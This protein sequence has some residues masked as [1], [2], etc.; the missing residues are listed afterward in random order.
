MTVYTFVEKPLLTQLKSMGWEVREQ[1]AG[2]TNPIWSMRNSFN[3]V[4]IEDEFVKALNQLNQYNG[5]PWLT[6]EQLYRL[7]GQFSVF[8]EPSLLACNHAFI[9][10]LYHCQVEKNWLSGEPFPLVRV[11]DFENWQANRFLAIN[12]YRVDSGSGSSQQTTIP[13]IVLFVNG[14]PLVVISCSDFSQTILDPMGAATHYLERILDNRLS[15][16]T[17]RTNSSL[18]QLFYTNQFLVASHG[19]AC[20]Y[21]AL[22]S[23]KPFYAK[24]QTIYPEEVEYT[25]AD[26]TGVIGKHRQQEQLVQGLLAPATLLNI[27]RCFT[28]FYKK[29]GQ[30]EKMVCRYQHYRAVHKALERLKKEQ[31]KARSGI[32]EHPQGSGKT[33]MM[34]F[35]INNIRAD[36]QLRD[37]KILVVGNHEM[38]MFI[39]ELLDETAYRL[40]TYADL[41]N[42][43]S[44]DASTLNLMSVSKLQAAAKSSENAFGLL[45][46]SDK[47]L[48]LSSDLNSTQYFN[49]T[50]AKAFDYFASALPGAVHLSFTSAGK[51]AEEVHQSS[52]LRSEDD[53]SRYIDAYSMRD[54]TKDGV[55]LQIHY[56]DRSD[57]SVILPQ[58]AADEGFAKEHG[59]FYR[60][61]MR[62]GHIATDIVEHY[63]EHILPHG[64]KGMVVCESKMTAVNYQYGI[65]RA[66]AAW[67]A[68]EQDKPLNQ[69]DKVLLEQMRFIDV[70]VVLSDSRVE[71]QIELNR[72][73]NESKEK[74][75]IANFKRDI[76]FTQ[77]ETGI[78]ILIV[79]DRLLT[80]YDAPLLQAMYIDKQL[81]DLNLLQAVA[82]VNRPYAGKLNGYVVD[83]RGLRNVLD[84]A[85]SLYWSN[86]QQDILSAVETQISQLE[87]NLKAL[88]RFFG[89]NG[90]TGL[91]NLVQQ[92]SIVGLADSKVFEEAVF[93]LKDNALRSKFVFLL[94]RVMKSLDTVLPDKAALIYQSPACGL[95]HVLAVAKERFKDHSINL[96][97]VGAKVR[98][99]VTDYLL[100]VGIDPTQPPIGLLSSDFVDVI[101]S[102]PSERARATELEYAIVDHCQA[103]AAKDPTLYQHFGDELETILQSNQDDWAELE[104]K[105]FELRAE[106]ER[107]RGQQG[108]LNIVYSELIAQIAFDGRCPA[109][110]TTVF[111]GLVT[112]VAAAIAKHESAKDAWL[113]PTEVV[114]LQGALNRLFILS[115]IDAVVQL[116]EKLTKSVMQV[117][118][119]LHMDSQ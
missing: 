104:R 23:Y 77:P 63:R 3:N 16:K 5:K 98:K 48:L 75:A 6:D 43:M 118:E 105:L 76:D 14:L 36:S 37:F 117:A 10:R 62:I 13:S 22:S 50:A 116:R 35:L 93:L 79:V 103:N 58:F 18:S 100:K 59:L 90:I 72:A 110:Y 44:D 32:I 25:D 17:Q 102:R 60:S 55:M 112:A 108:N 9:Q 113:K 86:D 26:V 78:A 92:P 97:P 95:M 19:T 115:K 69:Q 15:H 106:I 99:L 51:L 114:A 28:V 38:L 68:A 64:F 107:G 11:I 85:I 56:E 65:R 2:I 88:N 101:K 61:Q 73:I 66:I 80:G 39:A 53:F 54:A 87:S 74:N 7:Y 91:M 31:G 33:A 34:A 71:G 81:K 49:R 111:D 4:V 96:M 67:I 82:R 84:S 27:I 24:W 21:G 89:D 40:D 29:N 119:N 47:I 109:E 41:N 83:Y 57:P 52:W 42:A 1:G 45:N 8:N 70:Q 30:L 12:Q 20:Q 94:Q 46:R